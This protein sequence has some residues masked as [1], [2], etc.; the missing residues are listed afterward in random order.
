MKAP[1]SMGVSVSSPQQIHFDK[2]PYSSVSDTEGLRLSFRVPYCLA[3]IPP[4]SQLTEGALYPLSGTGAVGYAFALINPTVS[5]SS[6]TIGFPAPIVFISRSFKLYRFRS[7][8]FEFVTETTTSQTGTIAM[9]TSRDS[10][11]QTATGLTLTDISV[12]TVM[13]YPRSVSFPL[14]STQPARV[15]AAADLGSQD[16]D[17][18]LFYVRRDGS[19]TTGADL[20][21][22]Y[23]FTFFGVGDSTVS[24]VPQIV[25]RIY[26]TG[27]LDLYQMWSGAVTTLQTDLGRR[28]NRWHD[29]KS[30]P[31]ADEEKKDERKLVGP[32]EDRRRSDDAFYIVSPTSAPSG[33]AGP[34]GDARVLSQ[35]PASLK[36]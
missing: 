13:Q 34:G 26:A 12:G 25:G 7:L 19:D 33:R 6:S 5:D 21:M 22:E 11:D 24:S 23:Q 36:S 15:V 17:A 31:S 28:Q 27:V 32:G 8:A 18:P 35:R 14:W 2:A 20:R 9:A 4:A 1:V 10:T 3:V 16:R 30:V 29:G